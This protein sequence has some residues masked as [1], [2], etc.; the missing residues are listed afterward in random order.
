MT[1]KKINMAKLQ[2]Q[3]FDLYPKAKVLYFTEDGNC[4]LQKSPAV[5]HSK[6]SGSKWLSVDNPAFKVELERE[7]SELAAAEDEAKLSEAK[8]LLKD[9]HIDHSDYRRDIELVNNL[10]LDVAD[11][12]HGTIVSAIKEAQR[13]MGK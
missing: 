9:W 8:K 3:Y 1:K 13:K 12:K 5:A 11:R 10:K 6:K 7:A 2:A 4:F